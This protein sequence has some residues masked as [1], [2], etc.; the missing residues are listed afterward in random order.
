[1]AGEFASLST[2]E[3]VDRITT[4]AGH[5]NA[6]NYR[7]LAMIA[8]L[9]R[10]KGWAEWGV[11]SCAHWL[12]FKCGI[13]LG[14]AREKIRVALALEHLPRVA[15]A[16]AAGRLSYAKVREIT[17]VANA[18]NEDYLLNIGLCGTASH[19]SHLVR[20]YRRALDAEELTREA[21]QQRDQ[22]LWFYTEPD[23]SMSIRGRLPAEVGALF[24][25]ALEAAEDRLP[26]EHLPAGTHSEAERLRFR[27]KRVEALAVVAESFLASCP[28]DLTGADRHQIVVHVDAETLIRSEAGRCELEHGP[29]IAAETARR[30]ACDASVV[31]IIENAKGEPLSVGRKSRVIPPG[32]RRALN[33]RDQG[34][35]FP[36]CPFKRY[37]DGHHVNHWAHGGETK[38]SNLVTLCRFHHRLV[39]EGQIAIQTLDDGAFRFLRPDGRPFEDPTSTQGDAVALVIEHDVSGI[40]ITPSTALTGWRGE[41]MDY[42]LAVSCLLE[43]NRHA[44]TFPRERLSTSGKPELPPSLVHDDCHGIGEIEAAIARHH[45]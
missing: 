9:D 24:K 45:R 13:G 12:N 28:R 39:H 19:V 7:F 10:R 16:M 8:E 23:G 11:K 35:R 15:Q 2:A 14:A 29:S 21:I 43:R 1:M 27:K 33:A 3:L 44:K 17:R 26:I 41:R 36:G 30:L 37:V 25:K 6:A 5:L 4:L 22:C 34:C 42:H 20:G 40:R 32:I 38:L 18:A 31:S